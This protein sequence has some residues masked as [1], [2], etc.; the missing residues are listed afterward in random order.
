MLRWFG[1]TCSQCGAE[2][3]SS[4]GKSH[5]SP[6][7]SAAWVITRAQARELGLSP[8]AIQRRVTAG[9][10]NPHLPGVLVAANAPMTWRAPAD[11]SKR[12]GRSRVGDLASSRGCPVGADGFD[13]GPVEM[14]T[15]RDLRSRPGVVIHRVP[16]LGASSGSALPRP[17]RD[18][19]SQNAHRRGQRRPAPPG[20]AGSGV[21]VAPPVDMR[22]AAAS[23]SFRT[24]DAGT[25]GSRDPKHIAGIAT[26]G[27][28]NRERSGDEDH[29]ALE[30][31]RILSSGAAACCPRQGLR[32]A[33]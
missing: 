33:R 2:P 5:Q 32:G 30:D 29:P 1:A 8:S 31:K 28:P 21:R 26:V 13:T 25:Q 9:V 24:G 17:H 18:N 12:V 11:G 19:R 10:W 4:S 16:Q 27:D 6:R 7:R 15:T 22:G 3:Q 23:S 20:R 14:T